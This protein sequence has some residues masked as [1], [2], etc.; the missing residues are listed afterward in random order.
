[1][2]VLG[3]FYYYINLELAYEFLIRETQVRIQMKFYHPSI[4]I[5][6]IKDWKYLILEK[7]WNNW[8]SYKN[9][10]QQA[11]MLQPLGKYLRSSTNVK[12]KKK[13][14]L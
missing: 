8:N 7:K 10:H 9:Y 2:T 12:I 5:A 13:S 14:T 3:L 11:E 4:N 6:K 1:M